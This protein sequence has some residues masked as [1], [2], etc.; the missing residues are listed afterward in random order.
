MSVMVLDAGNSIIKAKIAKR[1]LG[2][3]AFP[4]AIQQLP[5][6]EYEKILS[7]TQIKGNSKDYF[8]VNGKPYVLGESAE[9]HGVISPRSGAARYTKDYCGVLAAVSLAQLYRR[10]REVAVFASHPPGDV[11]YREDLMK[12]IIGE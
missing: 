3:I 9:R 1:E 5:E 4:H 2:E 10:G 11:K 12:S 8:R 6:S 7:R